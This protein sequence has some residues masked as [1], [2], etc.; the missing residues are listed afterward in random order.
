MP[1]TLDDA[2]LADAERVLHWTWTDTG[3]RAQLPRTPRRV[4]LF[5][6]VILAVVGYCLL[7][8]TRPEIALLL[9]V[10]GVLGVAA[11]VLALSRRIW[12]PRL[13]GDDPVAE[14]IPQ[15]DHRLVEIEVDGSALRIGRR[16]FALIDI[17]E[18]RVVDGALEIV[19]VNLLH[20]E[21]V[22]RFARRAIQR[23]LVPF[24]SE[25]VAR[26]RASG[27]ERKLGERAARA[28]TAALRGRAG[29][30]SSR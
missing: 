3:F 11:H 24:V 23:V 12:F 14:W 21:P 17:E 26:A 28:A 5:V 7:V 4:L 30:I 16:R 6:S 9:S 8:L 29:S 15:E 22:P 19:L 1:P 10:L 20:A 18:I 25:A 13:F 27:G 2:S